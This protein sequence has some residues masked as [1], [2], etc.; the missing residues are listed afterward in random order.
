MPFIMPFTLLASAIPTTA[1]WSPKV[2]IVMILCN[3]I[4]IALGKM[5]LASTSSEPALPMP[6]FFGGM[7]MPAL[8]ASTSVGHVIG[9]GTILGLASMG[10]L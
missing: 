7:G 4:G 10:L 6:E 5:G 3:V 9:M 8:L 2:A 1:A